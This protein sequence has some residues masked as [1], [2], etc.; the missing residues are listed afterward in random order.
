MSKIYFGGKYHNAIYYGGK[1]HKAVYLGSTKVW[2]KAAAIINLFDSSV[3]DMSAYI[4]Y[5]TKTYK[6][7]TSDNL[8]TYFV[9]EPN[10][11]Y[12]VSLS[13]SSRFR[14]ASYNGIPANGTVLSNCVIHTLD[15]ND[16]TTQSGTTETLEI[17]T[18][19]SDTRV[20]I[21]YW[22]T[23]SDIAAATIRASIVV[24]KKGT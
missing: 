14:L 15:V 21:G 24:T 1:Y 8:V 6:T 3:T 4:Q 18:G 11:T 12:V 7:S 10:T 5:S 16:T 19:A 2:E 13:M 9:A 17:T 22:T 20:L 23:S